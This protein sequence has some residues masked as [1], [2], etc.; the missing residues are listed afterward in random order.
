MKIN[1]IRPYWRQLIRDLPEI[2]ELNGR[3]REGRREYIKNLELRRRLLGLDNDLSTL[4]LFGGIGLSLFSTISLYH[5]LLP[6]ILSN[7]PP[8]L[9][10]PES[11]MLITIGMSMAICYQYCS[12]YLNN[13]TDTAQR[14]SKIH[15]TAEN[16]RRKLRGEDILEGYENF[17]L[18]N[19]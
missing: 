19:L 4:Y 7:A 15:Y 8:I 5:T 10:S 16:Q 17:R 3:T 18:D 1:G 12:K 6:N 13:F 2:P 14:C 11:G 9:R